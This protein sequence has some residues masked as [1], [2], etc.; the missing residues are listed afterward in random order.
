MY[1]FVDAFNPLNNNQTT[2]PQC[3]N[4]IWKECLRKEYRPEEKR[5]LGEWEVA[6]C[7]SRV[8]RGS[9]HGP[10]VDGAPL[11]RPGFADEEPEEEGERKADAF[12]ATIF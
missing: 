11:S 2:L 12:D 4:K 5:N 10:K 6:Y 8:L 1:H 7:I 9:Y 3:A